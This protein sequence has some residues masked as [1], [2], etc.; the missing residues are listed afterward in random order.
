MTEFCGI[1]GSIGIMGCVRGWDN[2]APG[3]GE[4]RRIPLR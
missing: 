4:K 3:R 2:E 1:I